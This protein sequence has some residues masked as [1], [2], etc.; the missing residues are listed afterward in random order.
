MQWIKSNTGVF[1][2]GIL[3][4]ANIA[5]IENRIGNM[6]NRINNKIEREIS[7]VEAEISKVEREISKVEAEIKELRNLI[8]TL[9]A[10]NKTNK[11]NGRKPAGQKPSSSL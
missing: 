9:I 3:L 5:Y 11:A 1:T 6:E 7:K 10:E 2:L 8:I 4:M